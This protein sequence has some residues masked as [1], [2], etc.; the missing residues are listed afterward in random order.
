M[1][2]SERKIKV[3]R[4]EA[5]TSW[6]AMVNGVNQTQGPRPVVA[7]YSQVVPTNGGGLVLGNNVQ[8][9]SPQTNSELADLTK[10][11]LRRKIASTGL[12]TQTTPSHR[13]TTTCH[14]SLLIRR[15]WP[16]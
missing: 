7:P 12:P 6:A 8:F 11:W 15:A 10:S 1:G 13:T 2:K 5:E 3:E 4:A 14:S 9:T 16:T